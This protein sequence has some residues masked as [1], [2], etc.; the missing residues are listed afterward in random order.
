MS[1][2]T[3]ATNQTRSLSCSPPPSWPTRC[4]IKRTQNYNVTLHI[5]KI[6]AEVVNKMQ[7]SCHIMKSKN[8]LTA[9][10][11]REHE[12]LVENKPYKGFSY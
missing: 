3:S 10:G 9:T 4:L 6:I 8:S 5:N 2:I 1:F 7:S 12:Q 11:A